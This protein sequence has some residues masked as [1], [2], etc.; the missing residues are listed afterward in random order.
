MD[1]ETKKKI[2][3]SKLI[4][5]SGDY[6]IMLGWDTAGANYVVA[7]IFKKTKEYEGYS[8]KFSEEEVDTLIQDL[9]DLS[10]WRN[11]KRL[12]NKINQP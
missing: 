8:M 6:E 11:Y 2:Q 10:D 1:E 7:R 5:E 12:K 3:N 9:N 4:I